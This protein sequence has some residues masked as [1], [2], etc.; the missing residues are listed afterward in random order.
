MGHKICRYLETTFPHQ[1]NRSSTHF[2]W[3]PSYSV[4]DRSVHLP[5]ISGSFASLF[6]SCAYKESELSWRKQSQ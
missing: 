1:N 3:K 2:I 4:V 6:S 5:K